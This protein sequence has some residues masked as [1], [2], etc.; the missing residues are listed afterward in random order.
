M[1]T[2]LNLPER[3][4]RGD[5]VAVSRRNELPKADES[6]RQELRNLK[7]CCCAACFPWPSLLTMPLTYSALNVDL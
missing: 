3:A 4:R 6:G 7:P 2:N 5:L 1:N